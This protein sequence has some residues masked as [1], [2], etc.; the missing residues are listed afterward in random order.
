M[1]P[2]VELRAG[3]FI[4]IAP[5]T[6]KIVAADRICSAIMA[7]LTASPATVLDGDAW[8]RVVQVVPDQGSPSISSQTL[9]HSLQPAGLSRAVAHLCAKPVAGRMASSV[10]NA[11]A[12]RIQA[13]G[14]VNSFNCL[15][16]DQSSRETIGTALTCLEIRSAGGGSASDYTFD[17]TTMTSSLDLR[18]AG[19]AA[20]LS[21]IFGNFSVPRD[22]VA[23][24]RLTA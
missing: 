10:A 18:N 23:F 3:M 16:L 21:Q 9:S 13:L 4:V 17:V 20:D 11:V 12:S 1:T 22:A 7:K 19:T 8:Q 24:T 15:V 6:A 5:K 14:S 2:F